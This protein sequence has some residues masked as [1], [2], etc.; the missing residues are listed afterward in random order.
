[1]S[2]FLAYYWA[3]CFGALAA[4]VA[5]TLQFRRL[6]EGRVSDTETVRAFR[7]AAATLAGGRTVPP[8]RI[9]A[10]T[11]VSSGQQAASWG[12]FIWVAAETPAPAGFYVPGPHATAAQADPPG[13]FTGRGASAPLPCPTGFQC[14]NGLID[15]RYVVAS[16]GTTADTTLTEVA[17]GQLGVAAVTISN[18]RLGAT[19]EALTVTGIDLTGDPG[20]SLLFS[21]AAYAIGVGGTLPAG[22]SFDIGV[23]FDSAVFGSHSGQLAITTA[24]P[25]GAAG[26]SLSL[27]VTA[28]VPAPGTLAALLP[29]V[30][31]LL[32]GRR[33]PRRTGA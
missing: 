14:R 24:L 13:T 23:V 11:A 21:P 10:T 31:G 22:G 33:S 26:P 20:F 28:A 6:W 25:D 5:Y 19:G 30:F 18:Q 29:G 3:A 15:G 17:P 9:L 1:M 2:I 4:G 32:F 27:A 16:L 7:T 8:A 12:G